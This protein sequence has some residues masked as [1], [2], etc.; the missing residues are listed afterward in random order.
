M[1]KGP[2]IPPVVEQV[3]QAPHQP[4]IDVAKERGEILLRYRGLLRTIK[5][6]RTPDDTRLI[7][8]AFNIA[9]EAHKDQRRKSG[10][11]YIYH[12]LAV[13]R[14][15][16]E[17]IGLGTT[18]VVCAL[19]HDTVEDTDLTLEDVR[20]LFGPTVANIIDG[21]TKISGLQFGTDS[22][23]AENF[24]KVLLTLAQD[25]RVILIKL[26]DRLHN[27]RTLDS[28]VRDKQ[29]KIGSETLFLY[30]PLAHRLGLYSIKSE[31]EDLA[32][33]F[34]EPTVYLDI[35]QKL[36]KG[37]AVRKRFISRFT[38][39][40]RESLDK[41]GF[42]YEI[43]G[44]PKSIHSIYNKM[45][46]K[47]V[48]F[49]EV[50]DV[51]ALRIIIDTKQEL[52]KAD[53]WR[54]YSVVTDYYQPN[55]DRL[56]D[57]ISTPKANGYESLHTTVMSPGGRWVEVQIRSKRMDEIAEMGLAAHYRYKDDEEHASA[58]D[59][60]L[61]RVREVLEDP[62]SNA[63]DFVN[64]FKLNLFSDEIVVFTPKGDMRNLPSGATALDFAFD[65]HSHVG[66]Q[67][68]GAKV[69]H[70]LV[71]LSHKLRSGDQIEI[72][73]SKKQ[74]PKE[75][76]LNYVVTARARHKV[77]QAL[78][79]QKRK[80]A[81]V[82]REAAQRKLRSWGAKVDERNMAV[83]VEHHRATSS[84]DLFYRIA[85]GRVDLDILGTPTVRNGRLALPKIV[86]LEEEKPLEDVVSGIR[87]EASGALVI[88]DELQK[89]EYQLSTCCNP[90]PGDDVFGFITQGEGIRIHRVNCPNA[91]QLMSN[92]AYRIVKAR[93]KGKDSM[94][95]LAG[96][97]FSG[98]DEVGL[99]NKITSI[100]SHQHNVNMRSISFES[101][102]G[103]FEGR[104]MA[105][106][107]DTDHLSSLIEK[108]RRVHGV[109]SVERID[110]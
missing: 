69:N 45:L 53:C 37:E 11:P 93:W 70:T 74:Q 75:E 52:E 55:P 48:S 84:T 105:F 61:G 82:G 30:A 77:K 79:E 110:N 102:A 39:P 21:L 14:I 101:N 23:Q 59:D 7:R 22:I 24:R 49:E 81:V 98:I 36:K 83:L 5:G 103:I 26:A 99:V 97:R 16:S 28:M 78:R 96:L 2:N 47:N 56:R 104:V 62:S 18:S 3:H 12:P 29:L 106:V 1:D 17:E 27:M 66:R 46:K 44:R 54:V 40:I 8:K 92:F 95:F 67:C 20:D 91:V 10:E 57:W 88:G 100:I 51:F 4:H 19:L 80:L 86:V 15:C 107:Q 109:R 6:H 33:K 85:R 90:I 58:L 71:P 42:T 76:W 35:E 68:I 60:W 64:D 108:L 41:E 13:A 73:T 25:V 31:L 87:G 38:L 72:I 50:Y 63:I 32:L 34:K 94:E 43:K 89:L 9:L 65:I